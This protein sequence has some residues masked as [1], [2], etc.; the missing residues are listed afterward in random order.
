M[1]STKVFIWSLFIYF[2]H[3]TVNAMH[4]QGSINT[5]QLFKKHYFHTISMT[6]WMYRSARTILVPLALDWP[7]RVL[8]VVC[9]HFP[10]AIANRQ[11][12][13]VVFA[14][15]PFRHL[16]LLQVTIKTNCLKSSKCPKSA[17]ILDSTD[18]LHWWKWRTV[19]WPYYRCQ[20]RYQL[21]K[22]IEL[23]QIWALVRQLCRSKYTV[24][25]CYDL[26]TICQ[27]IK[28]FIKLLLQVRRCAVQVL[29]NYKFSCV[30][31]TTVAIASEQVKNKSTFKLYSRALSA[32]LN[33]QDDWIKC[34]ILCILFSFVSH[35]FD[36]ICQQ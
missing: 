29:K 19:S 21:K 25:I 27:I 14:P 5:E 8:S 28:L 15:Q 1:S 3:N 35:L 16:S 17:R 7:P 4:N 22:W 11:R 23:R 32:S 12:I 20:G 6:L 13:C 36:Y 33:D 34:W 10:C 31:K 24:N 30:S 9:A 26:Y 2:V 18:E